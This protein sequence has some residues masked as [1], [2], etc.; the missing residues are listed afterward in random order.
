MQ[1]RYVGDVGDY[2]K[3]ALLRRLCG[4]RGSPAIRL[5][6]V[7]CFFPDETHNN[8]GKHVS[9]LRDSAFAELDPLL[10]NKLDGLVRKANR[11]VSAVNKAGLFPKGTSYFS[12]SITSDV[13][14]RGSPAERLSH[15]EKWLEASL[16]E[17]AGCDFIFFDPDNGLDTSSVPKHH[18]KAGKYIFRDEILRFWERGQSLVIYHHTHRK[19]TSAA[20]VNDL[21]AQLRTALPGCIPAPL[22]FRRGSR[23]V[24]WLL[25]QS[26]RHGQVLER[27]A[28]EHL[29]SGWSKHFEAWGWPHKS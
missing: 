6:I 2:G 21:A 9:Y 13:A 10:H 27:R 16:R 24:F 20:Q 18:Q 14:Q 23:R 26:N 1:D 19:T 11:R 22:V 3:Y 5:G 8:D 28:K 4:A 29:Q 25:S 12:Q 7:W 15:R 17:T